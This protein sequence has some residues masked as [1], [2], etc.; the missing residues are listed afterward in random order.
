MDRPITGSPDVMWHRSGLIINIAQ[1]ILF[2]DKWVASFIYR[3][4]DWRLHARSCSYYQFTSS[5]IFTKRC[6]NPWME[7]TDRFSTFHHSCSL[8]EPNLTWPNYIICIHVHRIY[9][10]IG[11]QFHWSIVFHNISTC[12]RAHVMT[13]KQQSSSCSVHVYLY[14]CHWARD[15]S[16]GG[17]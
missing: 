7:K 2:D 17:G 3:D 4:I 12:P 14:V 9:V 15:G 13:K 5:Y 16:W 8:P 11:S 6:H 1:Y 10:T